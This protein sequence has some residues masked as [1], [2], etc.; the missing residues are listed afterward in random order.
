MCCCFHN[1]YCVLITIP[2]QSRSVRVP[3][4]QSSTKL[5]LRGIF[6]GSKVVRGP[7]WEWGQ[8]DGGDGKTGRVME[9][10]GWDNESC[11]S[12]AN[13][14]WVSGST[15]VYR[16]GHKGNVDLKY[17]Q[18]AVGGYFYREHMPVLGQ[19]EEQQPEAVASAAAAHA[20]PTYAVG[21]IVKVCLERDAL[22]HLQQG[23]GGWNPRMAEYLTKVGTVHRITDKGD[24][25]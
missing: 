21:D 11:R 4:R 16:L 18:P 7:D 3:T 12:V 24:I 13:V 9:I 10:R 14:S 23:H 5:Q 1:K 8:Q 15:N 22:M 20:R 17:L 25:R 6:V 2:N 19:P